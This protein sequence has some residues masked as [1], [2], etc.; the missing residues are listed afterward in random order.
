MH[1]EID[2]ATIDEKEIAVPEV[3]D[4]E[5]VVTLNKQGFDVAEDA[6]WLQ[7]IQPGSVAKN[8][9]YAEHV[10]KLAYLTRVGETYTIRES[11][12]SIQVLFVGVKNMGRKLQATYNP[13]ENVRPLCESWDGEY[14]AT[15]V[16]EPR[17]ERCGQM[18][19]NDKGLLSFTPKCPHAEWQEGSPPE[20]QDYHTLTFMNVDDGELLEM[21]LKSTSLKA[22]TDFLKKG[23][24]DAKAILRSERRAARKEKKPLPN[25]MNKAITLGVE[26][27]G[28]YFKLTVV[29]EDSKHAINMYPLAGYYKKQ[30]ENRRAE[31]A[32]KQEQFALQAEAEGEAIDLNETEFDPETGEL[33]VNK[34]EEVD[35]AVNFDA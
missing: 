1:Y 18:Y 13:K 14:P 10:G 35:K 30:L 17:S 20:C 7:I 26:N 34:I 2:L 23:L 9:S 21:S 5:K 31:Y 19:I 25:M 4:G 16:D 32:K 24:K 28:T 12:D 6:T 22:W 27:K 33:V 11:F 15:N 29:L 8:P 3:V